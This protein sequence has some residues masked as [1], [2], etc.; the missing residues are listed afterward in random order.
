MQF[1]G[2]AVQVLTSEEIKEASPMVSIRMLVALQSQCVSRLLRR[3]CSRTQ[4]CS[5]HLEKVIAFDDTLEIHGST[6]I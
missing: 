4:T 5:M 1:N 2:I 3:H 6:N